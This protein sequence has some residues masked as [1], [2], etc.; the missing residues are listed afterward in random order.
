MGHPSEVSEDRAMSQERL[1]TRR[2]T[3]ANTP[4]LETS[5]TASEI[6]V[7]AI[8]RLAS[9]IF[10]PRACHELHSGHASRH[11]CRSCDRRALW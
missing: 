3:S 2:P 7:A 10:W 4:S 9:W 1:S 6:A 11:R 8:Q 5:A